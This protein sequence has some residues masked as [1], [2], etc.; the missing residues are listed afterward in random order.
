MRWPLHG[1]RPFASDESLVHLYD[2][3]GRTYGRLPSEV[4]KLSWE[5]LMICARCVS[6]RS[7]RVN[8]A[9]KKR[10][11][12]ATIFPNASIMDMVDLI[13]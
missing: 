4:A 13:G 8:R 9:M 2:I 7:D 3:I 6:A 5:D 11:K 1:L 10:G 12:G